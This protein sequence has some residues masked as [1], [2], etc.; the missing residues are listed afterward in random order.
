LLLLAGIATTFLIVGN[1]PVHTIEAQGGPE[2]G[3]GSD[4]QA[5]PVPSSR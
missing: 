1:N 4:N 3:E 5:R 2:M